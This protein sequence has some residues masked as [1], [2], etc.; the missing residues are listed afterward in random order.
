MEHSRKGQALLR[1][2]N[3]DGKNNLL[4]CKNV[5][6]LL[7]D[8]RKSAGGNHF[9]CKLFHRLLLLKI[10]SI[11]FSVFYKSRAT[12]P[13]GNMALFNHILDFFIMKV[14]ALQKV[15]CKFQTALTA[16]IQQSCLLE[17][18]PKADPCMQAQILFLLSYQ[19]EFHLSG[20]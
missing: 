17:D 1:A 16:Q 10:P 18:F 19:P 14:Q 11:F 8:C 12:F 2:H 7:M 4:C 9:Q 13:T 3:V 15:F 6:L 20:L 5:R